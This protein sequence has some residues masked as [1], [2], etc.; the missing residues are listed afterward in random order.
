MTGP[1]G[2]YDSAREIAKFLDEAWIQLLE[3]MGGQTKV[4]SKEGT[5]YKILTDENTIRDIP[6]Y[7]LRKAKMSQELDKLENNFEIEPD[8]PNI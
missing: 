1:G 2:V 6:I 5:S 4:I 8:T 3:P 7:E